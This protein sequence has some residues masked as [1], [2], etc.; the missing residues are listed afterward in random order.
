MNSKAIKRQL[1]AAIAMVLVAAVALGS[2]TYAW[3]VSNNTVTAKTASISAQSNAPFLMIEKGD[4]T[5]TGSS[6]TSITFSEANTALYPA[7]VVANGTAPKFQ[8][9]YASSKAAATELANSR[10]DVG[11]AEAA[12]TAGFAIKETFHI[13]TA[14][15]KAGSFKNLK[16]S[17]VELSTDTGKLDNAVSVLLVCDTNWAVYKVSTDGTILDKYGDGT[18]VAGNNGAGILADTIAAGDDVTVNAYVFYD[19]SDSEVYTD[20][21]NALGTGG[22]T[23]TF[24]ATPVNTQGTEVNSPNAVSSAAASISGNTLSVSVANIPEGY[25]A[26]Y[27]WAKGGSAV[28]GATAASYTLTS[29][30]QDGSYTCT[31][32]LTKTDA[33]TITIVSNA[34]TATYSA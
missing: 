25:S 31:V 6:G 13:G 23:I 19:G 26:S 11:D 29:A 12:K 3:F 8:S 24:T 20:Q 33:P 16:V 7:Q 32:T 17:K 2:S 1:L 14:D 21:L 5:V 30:D 22:L 34:V 9:A 18:T 15:D 27:S 28:S 4:T 10:Y